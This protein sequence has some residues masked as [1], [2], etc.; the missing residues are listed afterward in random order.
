MCPAVTHSDFDHI[1]PMNQTCHFKNTPI[2]VFH[3]GNSPQKFAAQIATLKNTKDDSRP[4]FVMDTDRVDQLLNLW[5]QHM[6][7]VQP[8][9]SIKCNF[10]PVFLHFLSFH[11]SIG[12]NCTT[13]M[14]LETALNYIAPDRILCSNSCWTRNSLQQISDKG[15]NL[16]CFESE[17][18]LDRILTYH[19]NSELLLHICVNPESEDPN[20]LY[21]CSIE[22]AGALL[23]LTAQIGLN[24]V[25]I[26][27]CPGSDSS[28]QP[29][30]FWANTIKFGAELHQTG[31]AYGH[32]MR[33]LNIGDCF[34]SPINDY[35]YAQFVE[36]C[37]TINH[38][39]DANGFYSKQIC[40]MATPGRFFAGSV[41]SLITNVIAKRTIDASHVTNNDFDAGNDAFV[42]QV[43]DGYYGSFGCRIMPNCDPQCSPLFNNIPAEE[44]V[45]GTVIGTLGFDDPELDVVQP[46]CHFRQ[47][48]I[49]DW[50]IW[51][52]MGAYTMANVNTLDDDDGK[53]DERFDETPPI[54]YFASRQN[55]NRFCRYL[56][57]EK[58]MDSFDDADSLGSC[59]EQQHIMTDTEDENENVSSNDD[60]VNVFDEQDVETN[61][62]DNNFW[63]FAW[64]LHLE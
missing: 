31:L 14:E 12:F 56:Y 37:A 55:W 59:G 10:D 32:R 58:T 19:P 52:D 28:N 25:G 6:P 48:Y 26:S 4:F 51:A 60:I 20:A 13:K 11:Q 42:Y 27:F 40:V 64:P 35:E 8:F 57:D 34:V 46:I 61:G 5:F 3:D 50:L 36:T 63:M 29:P 22:N 43:N 53:N 62:D 41:F 21:G 9:Y 30:S 39:L 7:H 24:C 49:G 18:D 2:T 47:L 33:I 44:R 17:R 54:F 38:H 16:L 1:S 45:Y 23:R 15:V